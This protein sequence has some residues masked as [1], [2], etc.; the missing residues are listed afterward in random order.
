MFAEL[1]EMLAPL[2]LVVVVTVAGT[3]IVSYL[4]VVS[5][6]VFHADPARRADAQKLLERNP[7]SRLG[8]RR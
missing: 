6:A 2:P 8:R 5:V 4:M 7:L 3:Y 1:S